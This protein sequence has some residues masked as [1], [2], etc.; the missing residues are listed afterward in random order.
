VLKDP[1]NEV[2]AFA[3]FGGVRARL[4]DSTVATFVPNVPDYVANVGV[5]FNVATR[6]AERLSGTAY[7][8]F[9]GKKRLTEDGAITTSPFSRVSGKLAYSWPQGWSVFTQATW[10]PGNRYSELAINLGD[11]VTATPANIFVN[12]EPTLVVMAGVTYR[13]QTAAIPSATP[14][15]FTK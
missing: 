1:A 12:P 4:L 13:L 2:S 6:N 8:T 10:Y 3:N 5:D 11:P 9:V 7:I 15:L 14:N